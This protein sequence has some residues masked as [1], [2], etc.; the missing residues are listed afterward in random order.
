MSIIT[1][2]RGTF[3]GGK[4]LAES[5]AR[6]L[7]FA[8]IDREVIVERAA[9]NRVSQQELSDALEK[10]PSF[11]ERL[12]HKKYMYLVLM[13]AAL[14]EEVQRGRVIYHGNAGHLLLGGGAPVLRVR[15]IA[16]LDMRIRMAQER[17][18]LTAE[19]ALHHIEKVDRDRR[20][21]TQYLYGVDWGDPSLYDLVVNLQYVTIEQA[22]NAVAALVQTRCLEW[23]DECRRR[24]NDIVVRSR[25]RAALALHAA[26]S[27]LE[28]EVESRDGVID[29]KGEL[30]SMDELPEI[31]KVVREVPGVTGLHLNL[32]A[33]PP[34][35]HW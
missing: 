23:D 12:Q 5:L 16:P 4:S 17:L 34:A 14:A 35:V 7:G 3:S 33:L 6:R 18:C 30:P 19:E 32:D 2:S 9:V 10:P 31:E 26:T 22:C 24:L 28:V 11:L 20:K 25:V 8:C 27:H 1:I 21:W 29:M 15:I 13:Q